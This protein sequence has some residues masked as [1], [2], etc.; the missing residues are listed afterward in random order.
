MDLFD[1]EFEN[2][3][4][5]ETEPRVIA[6]STIALK[7]PE[8]AFTKL[9]SCAFLIRVWVFELYGTDPPITSVHGSVKKICPMWVT[10]EL[11]V[12]RTSK[13]TWLAPSDA[14]PGKI[15]LNSAIPFVAEMVEPRR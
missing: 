14:K 5:L 13:F 2:V 15:V 4:T 9:G 6:Y 3:R 1:T 7:P 11:G 12:G 8:F 10:E